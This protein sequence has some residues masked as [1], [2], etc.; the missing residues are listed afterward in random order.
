MKE[1]F[2]PIGSVLL[3]K[4]ATKKVMITGYCSAIPENPEKTYDY[5]GCLFPEGNLAGSDVVLFD[6]EQIGTIVHSGLVDEEFNTLNNEIKNALA[7]ENTNSVVDI[8]TMAAGDLSKLSANDLNNIVNSLKANMISEPSA[9]NEESFKIPTLTPPT[10]GGGGSMVKQEESKDDEVN[11]S[12][13]FSVENYEDVMK[14]EPVADGKPVLQLQLIGEDVQPNS[15]VA[16]NVDNSSAGEEG[17]TSIP[18]LI[19]L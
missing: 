8:S 14:E 15:T 9:F 6:H 11:I 2:L 16:L 4:G 17:N 3:L 10:L 12:D 13:E 1:K 18:G 7:E 19:K 5:V